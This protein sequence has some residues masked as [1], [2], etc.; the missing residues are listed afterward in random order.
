MPTKNPGPWIKPEAPGK[1]KPG[2]S[3]NPGNKKKN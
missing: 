3:G 2:K 1:N